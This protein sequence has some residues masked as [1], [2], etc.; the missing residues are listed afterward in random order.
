MAE[1]T[2]PSLTD[3]FFLGVFLNI[4]DDVLDDFCVCHAYTSSW[5]E[6][7]SPRLSLGYLCYS[8]PQ[9][10]EKIYTKIKLVSIILLKCRSQ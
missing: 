7:G 2:N 10:P 1:F 8:V 5:V 3:I 6:P 9:Y 4:V